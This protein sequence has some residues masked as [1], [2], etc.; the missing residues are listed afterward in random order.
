MLPSLDGRHALVTGGAGFIGGHLVEAL[1]ARGC[2]VSVIDDLSTGRLDNLPAA[3][4]RLRFARQSVLGSSVLATWAGECDLIFHLAA[5][6]GVELILEDPVRVLQSNVGGVQAVLQAAVPKRRPVLFASTSEIYGK[7]DKVPIG[8]EDDR[9]LG[10]TSH[11]R[12]SYSTSKAMGEYLALTFHRQYGLPV[13][14]CRLFNTVGPRQTGRYGMVVP[15]FVDQALA[16]G[17]LSVFG[18]GTQTRS[19]CDVSDTVAALLALAT[20]PAAGGEVFNV[21]GE[22]EITIRELA[23]RILELAGGGAEAIRYVPYEEA[24]APGFE[25]LRRRVPDTAKLRRLVGWRPR[26]GLEETLRRV[27]AWRRDAQ[28]PAAASTSR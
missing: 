27:I 24:Y 10:P 23:R 16:G 2:R 6:V 3:G 20:T 8:E 25:D 1:L 21:G 22:R 28:R 18:D 15:R 19:F 11:A 5:A 14:I 12:W 17:P 4:D 13:V 7:N 9:V 26:V